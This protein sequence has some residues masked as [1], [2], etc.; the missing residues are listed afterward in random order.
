MSAPRKSLSLRDQL[1]RRVGARDQI[2]TGDPHVNNGNGGPGITETYALNAADRGT[3]RHGPAASTSLKRQP[4][5]SVTRLRLL[6]RHIRSPLTPG[7]ILPLRLPRTR[8]ARPYDRFSDAPDSIQR[9]VHQSCLETDSRRLSF[10]CEN[11]V[12]G[13]SNGSSERRDGSSTVGYQPPVER[14]PTTVGL[15]R[16][17]QHVTLLS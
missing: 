5:L 3:G 17:H 15:L 10:H 2:R 6:S 14:T 8:P 16:C 11:K 9:A 12:L 13:I 7:S 4:S 1:A